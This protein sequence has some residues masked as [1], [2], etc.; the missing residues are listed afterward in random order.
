MATRTGVVLGPSVSPVRAPDS[1]ETAARSPATTEATSVCSLPRKRNRPCNRSS[2]PSRLFTSRSPPVTVPDSTLNTDSCPTN[3]SA[4]VLNT[5]MSD[6]PSADGVI[7]TISV[8][9]T[10]SAGRAS[11]E[12]PSSQ[13]K[14]ASRS[15]PTPV[16]AEPTSTGNTRQSSTAAA[17]VVSSSAT[18]SSSPDRYRSSRSSSPDDDLLDHGFVELV[19]LGGDVGGHRRHVV[20]TARLVVERLLGQDVGDAVQ[21]G[22]FAERQ[23]QRRERAAERRPQLVEHGVEVGSVL[24]VLVHEHQPRQP[25]AAASRHSSSVCTCT[26]STA[27]TT[28]TARSATPSAACTSPMKSG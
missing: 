15:M 6:C 22:G 5:W 19:L 1:F 16:S 24:V 21:R 14:S 20:P 27:L 17:S 28:K 8:P 25:H 4:I 18:V 9:A 12:G 26:P 23:L 3:G 10:T 11:G 13:M 2:V 7:G